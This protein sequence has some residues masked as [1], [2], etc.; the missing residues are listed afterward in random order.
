M[1]VL[2]HCNR[3]CF[4]LFDIRPFSIIQ[5]YAGLSAVG[6]I[7]LVTFLRKIRIGIQYIFQ[8]HIQ[9]I[10]YFLIPRYSHNIMGLG[11]KGGNGTKYFRVLRTVA[12]YHIYFSLLQIRIEIAVLE[13]VL[14]VI[15]D[16][17]ANSIALYKL[18]QPADIFPGIFINANAFPLHASPVKCL[19]AA[20]IPARQKNGFSKSRIIIRIGK[21]F[22]HA[23]QIIGSPHQIIFTVQK[24]FCQGFTV[25]T[26][27]FVFPS[28]ILCNFIQIIH[29]NTVSGSV[30][31]CLGE[32]LHLRKCHAQSLI[33]FVFFCPNH[34]TWQ[35]DRKK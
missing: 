1:P 10:Q 14:A 5:V 23:L 13:L 11:V 19:D 7:S 24:L 26:D 9:S 35:K 20:V 4:L 15:S 31:A 6:E 22:L 3:H 8:C 33:L 2:Y 12:E 25:G 28:G 27:I 16:G 34:I 18:F 30:S 21:V 32:S 17:T 29:H